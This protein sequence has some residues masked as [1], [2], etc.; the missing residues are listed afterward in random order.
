MHEPQGASHD[1]LYK[2][3]PCPQHFTRILDDVVAGLQA[4]Q[5][6]SKRVNG[7]IRDMK[8]CQ[9]VSGALSIGCQFLGIFFV[10]LRPCSR[11]LVQRIMAEGKGIP[12]VMPETPGEGV[13]DLGKGK[14]GK[15]MAIKGKLQAKGKDLSWL[16][17]AK[18]KDWFKGKFHATGKGSAHGAK[19]EEV[20]HTSSNS[21]LSNLPE[22]K[23]G[24]SKN[25]SDPDS[26]S[27]FLV[28][29]LH[30]WALLFCM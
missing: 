16:K 8:T 2:G 22:N 14:K 28:S 5:N 1:C 26:R 24:P 23:G 30:L 12:A 10:H 4:C 21:D 7:T 27:L 3:M 29:I 20:L 25:G 19:T 13:A 17:G 11:I 15:M 9:N 18:G 6:V